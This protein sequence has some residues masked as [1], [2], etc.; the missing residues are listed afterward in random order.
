MK[1]NTFNLKSFNSLPI[2][3]ILRHISLEEIRPI[4][5]IYL[6]AGFTTVEVTMNT[7]NVLKIITTLKQDFP[8]LNVGAGTVCSI[9]DLKK[10]LEAGA[11]FIVTPI[12]SKNIINH[13]VKEQIPVFPGAYSPTEIH[14]AYSLGATA[15]KV[16]PAT[17]LGPTYI[18]D[19]LGPLN[20]IK[21][22]PTGGLTK[23][24][25][26]SFLDAGAFG[27][28]MGNSLFDKALIKTKDYNCLENHFNQIASIVKSKI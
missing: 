21:L 17:Q 12:T 25:L 6:A 1:K 23:E 13:C 11:S 14:L 10:A 19:I 5:P 26:L 27:V 24:N 7:E 3:G 8:S 16:F 2:I 20:N 15:V 22:L 9:S 28:G 18:K 4:I